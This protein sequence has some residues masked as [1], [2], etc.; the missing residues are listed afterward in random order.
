M[1][2]T[3]WAISCFIV[4]HLLALFVRALPPRE[5]YPAS[6][7]APRVAGAG[8]F[9]TPVLDL[10]AQGLRPVAL[11]LGS[12]TRPIGRAA[13]LYLNTIGFAQQWRM[14]SHPPTVDQYVRLRYYV[15]R[16]GGSVP[17]HVEWVATELI[18]P[19]SPEYE[20]RLARSYL[21]SSRDKAIMV[22]LENFQ[23]LRE[24]MVLRDDLR[25]SE[26]PDYVAPVLRYFA[27][28][29]ERDRL[30]PGEQLLRTEFWYGFA[31]MTAPGQAKDAELRRGRRLV[32]EKYANG[33]VENRAAGLAYPPYHASET[34][35]DIT[36]V[37]EYYEP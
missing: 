30:V 19:A 26:L 7:F 11:T 29:F 18:V 2:S 24:G 20:V 33:P 8:T 12:V 21:D 1:S 14:F 13:N 23:R 10:A 37:F 4:W 22:A 5:L 34:E 36:W 15:G 32:L 9:V 17:S 16:A 3:R 35:G 28:R 31:P 25:A 27:R 6:D